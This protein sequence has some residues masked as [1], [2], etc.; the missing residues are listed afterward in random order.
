MKENNIPKNP[1]YDDN[2]KSKNFKVTKE[3]FEELFI[4]KNMRYK[5]IADMLGC[6]EKQLKRKNKNE[7]K[8]EKSQ[9]LLKE[10]RTE[11]FTKKYGEGVTAPRQIPEVQEKIVNTYFSKYGVKNPSQNKEVQEKRSI[12]Y[13]EK[14]GFENPFSNPDIKEKIKN[15]YREK[16]G[17]EITNPSQVPDIHN[18]AIS[19][20]RY[21]RGLQYGHNENEIN[22]VS[23]RDKLLEFIESVSPSDRTITK[24][25]NMLHYDDSV[26]G[27]YIH[28]YRLEDYVHIQTQRSSYE[29]EITNYIENILEARYNINKNIKGIL[30][31]KLQE[32]DI[33]IPE[34]G[35]GI[36]F[37]GSYWHSE[38]FKNMN[39][40]QTKTLDGESIGINIYNIFEYEWDDDNLKEKIKNQI[41]H[42][43]SSPVKSLYA[44]KCYVKEITRDEK[45]EFLDMYHL[46]GNDNSN[47]YIGLYT[48]TDELV[49][50]MTFCNPRFTKGCNWELSRFCNKKETQVIGGASKLLKYFER[51]YCKSG[52]IILTY[53]DIGKTTGKVYGEIGFT[54][55]HISKPS[56]VWWKSHNPVI[57]RY[58]SQISNEIK[59]MHK[60]G[61]KRI[62]NCGNKVWKKVV[63]K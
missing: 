4:T 14:T 55:D 41:K 53:S 16:Y 3:Q 12:S 33:Y 63:K 35:L 25:A 20:S 23:S 54:M 34:L 17:D 52:D 37:N 49:S 48:K 10:Q 60:N 2:L 51:K 29:I 62:Y 59:T 8:I 40:H 46:Q 44:R 39:Y 28:L 15:H 27:K 50:V 56:Y 6:S 57:S 61:Y 11:T 43:I 24:L 30:P 32:L 18:K 21:V 22:I 7:W 47:I 42:R 19:M 1:D 5:E 13:K 31:N 38:E 45:K 26:F 36:E 9:K 58:Q